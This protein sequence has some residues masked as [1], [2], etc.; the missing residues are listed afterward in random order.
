MF[1]YITSKDN[2]HLSQQHQRQHYNAGAKQNGAVSSGAKPKEAMSSQ[3]HQL[4][5]PMQQ[6][7]LEGTEYNYQNQQG[8]KPMSPNH[9]QP[10]Q[11]HDYNNTQNGAVRSRPRTR[12]PESQAPYQSEKSFMP[13]N[14]PTNQLQTDL[15]SPDR[16]FQPIS[17][18]EN[19]HH[20]QAFDSVS[21]PRQREYGNKYLQDGSGPSASR[22]YR[23]EQN[24]TQNYSAGRNL[25]QGHSPYETAAHSRQDEHD[26]SK[27]HSHGAG[28]PNGSAKPQQFINLQP[29]EANHRPRTSSS[30]RKNTA[31]D[32]ED[33][34]DGGF[35][36]RERIPSSST[37]V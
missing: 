23:H 37:V 2:K 28:R 27:L 32:N 16:T 6:F 9:K 25:S 3:G 14:N 13:V 7:N 11:P 1:Q 4:R 15:P 20:R 33:D 19:R 30:H 29:P 21:S 8:V 10:Q 26:Y 22:N 5:Q 35:M 34:D 12:Q 17:V 36:S 18:L 24:S 31:D